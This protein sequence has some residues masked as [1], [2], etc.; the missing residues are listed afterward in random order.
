MMDETIGSK[1]NS[2][3]LRHLKRQVRKIRKVEQD[4]FRP[5]LIYGRLE[6]VETLGTGG[7]FSPKTL[8]YERS[9]S[10]SGNFTIAYLPAC[11]LTQ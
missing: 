5:N 1:V 11:N 4:L 10:M 7:D 9:L 2:P 3:R 8:T 6:P